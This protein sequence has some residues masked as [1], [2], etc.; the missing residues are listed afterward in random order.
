MAYLMGGST[1]VLGIAVLVLVQESEMWSTR[2]TARRE[3]H[4]RREPLFN[5]A[6]RADLIAGTVLFGSMLVGL[7]AAFL[8]MPTWA[9]SMVPEA[10]Q[11]DVRTLINV[12]IGVGSV[13]GGFVAGPLADALG[14]RRAAAIGYVGCAVVTA[15]L[16]IPAQG[17]GPVLYTLTFL[18]SFFIG[19][20]QGVLVGYVPELFPT[21]IRGAAT[22]ICYNAGRLVTVVAILSAAP[23]IGFFGGYSPA[24]LTFGLAY[25]VGLAAL[26]R[27][28]ET[29][30]AGL[31]A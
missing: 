10:Q 11:R 15:V 24:I 3:H 1:V 18:L 31:P 20:N 16:F 21:L 8:W 22:G 19:N 29:R 28:R 2:E 13:A 17:V 25:L 30:G 12:L 7:W 9:S 23:L 5:S 26:M 27:A 4:E 14:R 6:H